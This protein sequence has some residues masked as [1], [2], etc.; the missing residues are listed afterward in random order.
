MEHEV[1][2]WGDLDSV[3]GDLDERVNPRRDAFD[4]RHAAPFAALDSVGDSADD[5]DERAI[6]RDAIRG[7][8]GE[9]GEKAERGEQGEKGELV[10]FGDLDRIDGDAD[11]RAVPP[12]AVRG[13]Q[14]D[15]TPLGDLDRIEGDVDERANPPE[16]RDRANAY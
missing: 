9:R 14:G 6:P 16:G 4:D 5:T 13:E 3:D 10:P 11:E 1:L 2:P 15:L 8:K 7:A 12:D